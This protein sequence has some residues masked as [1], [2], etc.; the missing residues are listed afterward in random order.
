MGYYVNMCNAEGV[1][2]VDTSFVRMHLYDR[3]QQVRCSKPRS[4]QSYPERIMHGGNE[5]LPNFPAKTHQTH[6]LPRW[7]V[8]RRRSA[9][10]QYL[11]RYG[12]SCHVRRGLIYLLFLP[13]IKD[14]S[15]EDRPW[16][17]KHQRPALV[18]VLITDYHAT[19]QATAFTPHAEYRRR[20]TV[21][22]LI[23]RNPWT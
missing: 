10:Q 17:R 15:Q 16:C 9:C 20:R 8:R 7:T 1:H 13:T 2:H 5:M 19:R 11:E 18:K 4:S 22:S 21:L 14:L 3:A 23:L 6:Q 12:A